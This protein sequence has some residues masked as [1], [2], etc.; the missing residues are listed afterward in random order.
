MIQDEYNQFKNIEP[1]PVQEYKKLGMALRWWPGLN[2]ARF[3][4][5]R[6]YKYYAYFLS[7]RC[8]L[9]SSYNSS[10]VNLI[11][12]AMQQQWY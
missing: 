9:I 3:L 7:I 11:M 10:D 5:I 12:I 4:Y 2:L 6:F 1:Y 8:Y